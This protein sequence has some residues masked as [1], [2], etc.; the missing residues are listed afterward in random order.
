MVKLYVMCTE[1]IVQILR[2]SVSGAN[3]TIIEFSPDTV[4]RFEFS[5]VVVNIELVCPPSEKVIEYT[6]ALYDIYVKCWHAG[7]FIFRW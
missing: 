7:R 1:Y 2:V 6:W 5:N 3:F 4:Y